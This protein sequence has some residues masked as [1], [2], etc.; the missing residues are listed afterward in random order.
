MGARRFAEIIGRPE[1]FARGVI[2]AWKLAHPEH[3]PHFASL[4]Q[5]GEMYR[6]VLPWSGRARLAYYSEALNFYIQGTGSDVAK[7]AL[8][9]AEAAG[10]PCIGLIHDELMLLVR[11]QDAEEAGRILA[12]CMVEAGEEVCPNVPWKQDFEIV[13]RWPS[14][15]LTLAGNDGILVLSSPLRR[16]RR[17]THNE[18]REAGCH[19]VQ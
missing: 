5:Q 14:K 19:A 10:L 15:G 7:E 16:G 3:R 18:R 4:Q 13:D 8:R 12:R 2:Q 17:R 9:R 1:S 11:E 6:A